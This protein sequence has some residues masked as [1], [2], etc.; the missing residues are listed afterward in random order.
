M[1]EAGTV[2]HLARSG[3]LIIKATSPVREGSFLVDE[4]G[5]SAGRVLEILGPVTAPYLSAQP[6]T[7]R[8]ERLVGTKLFVDEKAASDFRQRRNFGRGRES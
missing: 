7:E 8:I 1:Q 5:R 6:S 4:N 3:R 2:M